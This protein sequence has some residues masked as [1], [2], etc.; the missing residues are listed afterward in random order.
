MGNRIREWRERRDLSLEAL[1]HDAGISPSY[2]SRLETAK[3]N[4][5]LRTLAKLANALGVGQKDLVEA[6]PPV[7]VESESFLPAPAHNS[8]TGTDHTRARPDTPEKRIAREAMAIAIE[9]TYAALDKTPTDGETAALVRA[10]LEVYEAQ[11]VLARRR[12]RVVG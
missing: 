7:N 6:T 9:E 11:K 3:R 10:S 8:S 12:R 5:S 1:A 2:L 4:V